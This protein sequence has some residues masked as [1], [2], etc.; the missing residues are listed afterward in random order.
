MG[1]GHNMFA[2]LTAYINF[3]SLLTAVIALCVLL[4]GFRLLVSGG[5]FIAKLIKNRGMIKGYQS[6]KVD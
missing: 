2:A 1:A 3:Q 4:V 6:N 5:I